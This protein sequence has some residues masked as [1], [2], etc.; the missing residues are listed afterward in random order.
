MHAATLPR[1]LLHWPGASPSMQERAPGRSL[2]LRV[3]I[4]EKDVC[5]AKAGVRRCPWQCRRRRMAL[6]ACT[7]ARSSADDNVENHIEM[8]AVAWLWCVMKGAQT[9]KTDCQSPQLH[10]CNL[11]QVKMRQHPGM[12]EVFTASSTKVLQ[13]APLLGLAGVRQHTGF[14]RSSPQGLSRRN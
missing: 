12:P 6:R 9:H 11:V 4:A 2:Q 14:V 1:Q 5:R 7:L 8:Q 10:E 13:L 3:A